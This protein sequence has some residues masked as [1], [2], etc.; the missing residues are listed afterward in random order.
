MTEKY[1]D[2]EQ[3]L[4]R[5]FE[6]ARDLD[7][8][9]AIKSKDHKYGNHI[10]LLLYKILKKADGIAKITPNLNFTKIIVTFD[11]EEMGSLEDVHETIRDAIIQGCET[12][13]NEYICSK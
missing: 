10:F 8:K 11:D 4:I 5:A 6:V 9:V 3:K 13:L 7:F 12:F 2:D 1:K